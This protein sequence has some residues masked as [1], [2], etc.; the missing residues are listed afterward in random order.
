MRTRYTAI[1][2]L[3]PAA[4]LWI[5]LQLHADQSGRPE[6]AAEMVAAAEGALKATIDSQDAGAGATIEDVYQ[7]SRRLMSAEQREGKKGARASHLERMRTLHDKTTARFNAG[8]AT[9]DAS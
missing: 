5:G 4:V 9:Q 3:V 8:A 1:V 7:W 6:R 2:A